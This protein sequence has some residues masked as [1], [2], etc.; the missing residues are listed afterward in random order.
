MDIQ[1]KDMMLYG[2]MGLGAWKQGK[3]VRK[4]MKLHKKIPKFGKKAKLALAKRKQRAAIWNKRKENARR[5][6]QIME[7]RSKKITKGTGIVSKW[8]WKRYV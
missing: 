2:K 1:T 8:I 6:I 4:L 7:R 3:K 5:T